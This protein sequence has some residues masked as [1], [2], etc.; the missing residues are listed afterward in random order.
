[1]RTFAMN[2]LV[3][4]AIPQQMLDQDKTPTYHELNGKELQKALLIKLKEEADEVIAELDNDEAFVEELADVQE[5]LDRL[6]E[7]RRI[8]AGKLK[9]IQARKREKRGGFS[10]GYYVE[11]IAL[12]DDNE[13]VEYYAQRPLQ[14]HEVL[15]PEKELTPPHIE[16]GLY[17]HSKG[18]YYEVL[19]VGCHSETQE[20]LVIYRSLYEKSGAP[21][22]WARPHTMF[23]EMIE[24]DG[25]QIPR[26]KKV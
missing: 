6:H 15:A 22:L 12:D 17:Q 21:E 19:G 7:I 9:D 14:Y 4:D 26:F 18:S 10:Q 24:K 8:D 5:V 13:W 11:T 3:R 1:M 25:E 20:Y 23:T 2:K 16:P